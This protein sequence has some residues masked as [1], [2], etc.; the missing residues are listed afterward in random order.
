MSGLIYAKFPDMAA[1]S[2]N[3]FSETEGEL[4]FADNFAYFAKVSC[5]TSA[6][7][8]PEFCPMQTPNIINNM[9]KA[10]LFCTACAVI[11]ACSA[12]CTKDTPPPVNKTAELKAV[13]P[14]EMPSVWESGS[15]LAIFNGNGVTGMDVADGSG[16]KQAEFTLDPKPEG[17]FL[18]CYPW[19]ASMGDS[20]ESIKYSVPTIQQEGTDY[21]L[22]FGKGNLE[23]SGE[24][25]LQNV[26]SVIEIDILSDG[27]G[28]GERL[29][30]IELS[31]TDGQTVLAG[32]FH[33]D[34][35][36]GNQDWKDGMLHTSVTY[37][38]SSDSESAVLSAGTPAKAFIV[39]ASGTIA[40]DYR[41]KIDVSTEKDSW[42][43][44]EDIKSVIAGGIY[45]K[46]LTLGQPPVS[47]SENGAA[48]APQP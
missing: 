34:L 41:L 36:T 2:E 37:M 33:I 15:K 7:A 43:F 26:F 1:R 32:D 44:T 5:I 16:S 10:L 35:N 4:A 13:L 6:Q 22:F 42:T 11:A 45:K 39:I 18:L 48:T 9:K 29:K 25:T 40:S 3:A 21:S 8:D 24:V 27:Y 23:S 38:F 20:A 31:S 28:S 14:D 12:S 19:T 46:E 17:D 47:L 30:S